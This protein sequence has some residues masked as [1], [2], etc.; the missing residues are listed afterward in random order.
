[1]DKPVES[2]RRRRGAAG[3]AATRADLAATP[4]RRK[5]SGTSRSPSKRRPGGNAPKEMAHSMTEPSKEDTV[6]NQQLQE[7]PT[8]TTKWAPWW[9]YLVIIVAANHLRRAALPDGSAPRRA[10]RI[11]TR[12][13]R[14]A[15]RH[16]HHHLP[17][18]HPDWWSADHV[19]ESMN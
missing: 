11:R 19:A 9:V 2:T 14:G 6:R 5:P 17:R 12:L 7:R 8:M 10:S 13:L 3:T 1:M 15:L 4:P 18:R 16:H